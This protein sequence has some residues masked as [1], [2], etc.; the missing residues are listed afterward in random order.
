MASN[1]T[2][3]QTEIQAKPTVTGNVQDDFI[4]YIIIIVNISII[5]CATTYLVS[6]IW[7]LQHINTKKLWN[8]IL[9]R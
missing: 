1:T 3:S 9:P 2:H 8:S 7:P 4:N 6:N 5:T